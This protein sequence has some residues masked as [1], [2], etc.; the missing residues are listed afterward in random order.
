MIKRL[1]T[2]TLL[3]TVAVSMS[4]QFHGMPIDV[5]SALYEPT[6]VQRSL[7]PRKYEV[8]GTVGTGVEIGRGYATTYLAASPRVDYHPNDKL[9]LTVGFSVMGTMDPNRFMLRGNQPRSLTPRKNGNASAAIAAY[10]AAQYQVNDR[11]WVAA[12]LFHAGGQMIM[13]TTFTPWGYIPGGWTADIN[14]TAFSAAMRWKVGDDTYI[15]LQ[16]QIIRDGTGQL[17]PYYTSPFYNSYMYG[18]GGNWLPYGGFGGWG[19]VYGWNG[20]AAY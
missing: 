8:H 4:A 17:W 13:P 15:N 3:L 10:I 6:E 5:D 1:I 14:L 11:L 18:F 20:W 9:T 19:G 2:I 12:S 16:C 7:T